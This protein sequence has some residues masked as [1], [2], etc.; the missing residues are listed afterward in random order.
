[1][2]ARRIAIPLL[3]ALLA[4]EADV[5]DVSAPGYPTTR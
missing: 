4:T 5:Y 1:M 3:G 2:I